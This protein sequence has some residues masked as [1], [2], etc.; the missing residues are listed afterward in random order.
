MA[1]KIYFAITLVITLALTSCGYL[2]EPPVKKDSVYVADDMG[3]TCEIDPDKF[4]QFFNQDITEEINCFESNLMS[5][6][7]YVERDDVKYIN[8]EELGRF[9]LKFF[10]DF[11][12]STIKSLQIVFD[13]NSVIV[14][15][16]PSKLSVENIPKIAN[17]I[18]SLNKQS[19][20]LKKSLQNFNDSEFWNS[21]TDLNITATKMQEDMMGLLH[22]F[23]SKDNYSIDIIKSLQL[24]STNFDIEINHE[25][26]DGL[27]FIKR[28]FLG[29]DSNILTH[30]EFKDLIEKSPQML[31]I[32]FDFIYV[33]EE[34]FTKFSTLIDFFQ[35]RLFDLFKL[36]H[37]DNGNDLVLSVE[38]F[39]KFDKSIDLI[40]LDTPNFLSNSQ[41]TF[42]NS[43]KD[44][45]KYIKTL[46]AIKPYALDSLPNFHKNDLRL[47]FTYLD[48]VLNIIK[49]DFPRL[50]SFEDIIAPNNYSIFL[51]TLERVQNNSKTS[52]RKF[53]AQLPYIDVRNIF[54]HITS[55]LTDLDFKIDY[56]LLELL[57]SAKKLFLGGLR[58]IMA[59][60]DLF[61]LL[62]ST[63]TYGDIYYK[64]RANFLN[65]QKTN[66]EKY[67][68]YV[69][70]FEEMTKYFYQSDKSE[71]I[72][73]F[74][75]FQHI[76]KAITKGLINADFDITQNEVEIFI[77][78]FKD[79][80]P[81][82]TTGNDEFYTGD[83]IGL[84]LT[85]SKLTI[86]TFFYVGDVY[87][88]L[89]TWTPLRADEISK[90][91]E[92]ITSSFMDKVKTDIANSPYKIPPIDIKELFER[93]MP[94]WNY[95][96]L[97]EYL[98]FLSSAMSFK[99][100][101]LGGKDRVLTHSELLSMIDK[102]PSIVKLGE[103]LTSSIH[104]QTDITKYYDFNYLQDILVEAR[105]IPYSHTPETVLFEK[106]QLLDMLSKLDIEFRPQIE[107]LLPI[108]LNLKGSI[109]NNSN[110]IFYMSDINVAFNTLFDI[111]QNIIYGQK[112][113]HELS[114]NSFQTYSLKSFE[115]NQQEEKYRESFIESYKKLQ[116][117]R[118]I[119]GYQFFLPEKT[120]TEYG[121]IEYDLIK[122]VYGF[123]L[124]KYG[125]VKQNGILS[126]SPDEFANM[127]LE[128]KDLLVA[129][130]MWTK[131]FKN[132][133]FNTITMA[134]L[135]QKNSNGDMAMDLFEGTDYLSSILT[136]LK[137][138]EAYYNNMKDRCENKFDLLVSPPEALGNPAYGITCFRDN[139]FDSIMHDMGLE[140]YLGPMK[141]FM[142]DSSLDE[143]NRYLFNIE[144][145]ARDYPNPEIPID[146]KDVMFVIGAMIN[147]ESMMMR[148]DK[149][150]NNILDNRELRDAF[151]LYKN[152]LIKF[153]GLT[154]KQHKYAES[155]FLYMIKYQK[156]PTKFDLITFHTFGKKSD[157]TASRHQIASLLSYFVSQ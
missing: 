47:L 126:L 122:K 142:E 79:I 80:K 50:D 27:L 111:F 59:P 56:D 124:N 25:M 42:V 49:E 123:L 151:K 24:I 145:F 138:G 121:L 88:N 113:Y 118:T 64:L 30:S 91:L 115:N 139:F 9:I 38:E 10:P 46:K 20:K 4:L 149:N 33:K 87:D 19:I 43:L 3:K 94:A 105:K 12:E 132:F 14:N 15:D 77:N 40:I 153:A 135:F 62:D 35:S 63:V 141:S 136:S 106:E 143:M 148:Y 17:L 133:S 86:L 110:E 76:S 65:N 32:I 69:S 51:N 68:T 125:S 74:D 109:L 102:I 34:H 120:H 60:G 130:N 99:K 129:I 44:L 82:I 57:Y 28:L 31:S 104:P 78:T 37:I 134:D 7:E 97:N 1:Y 26:V 85:Y 152:V 13:L 84:M 45:K 107:E 2:S 36:A 16:P 128:F 95:L 29:G 58:D 147:I 6:V 146:Y 22:N 100:L 96:E 21:R 54:N 131:N 71:E 116:N 157:I 144:K 70:I 23:P 108:I 66:Q 81:V 93:G 52:I 90:H 154:K 127:I 67:L 11:G 117:S 83:D 39:N 92:Q 8:E 112:F 103:F 72:I 5:F 150:H 89:T 75:E 18:R 114:L 61:K 101:L 156:Q 48:I 41:Q 155:I 137:V 119:T 140:N 98:P 53:D 55:L 73:S